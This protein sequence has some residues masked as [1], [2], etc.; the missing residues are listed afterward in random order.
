[1]SSTIT[2]VAKG[3][4][5]VMN[6]LEARKKYSEL[7]ASIEEPT[8]KQQ[9]ERLRQILAEFVKQHLGEDS[10]TLAEPEK[11]MEK[12]VE[13]SLKD[14]ER[15]IN[16][17]HKTFEKQDVKEKFTSKTLE[18]EITE[19]KKEMGKMNELLLKIDNNN[20]SPKHQSAL[21][22]LLD[23]IRYILAHTPDMS[24]TWHQLA[25][26]VSA[27]MVDIVGFFDIAWKGDRHTRDTITKHL[28]DTATLVVKE[29]QSLKLEDPVKAE[30]EK[31]KQ[32][33]DELTN[34][35]S[36]APIPGAAEQRINSQEPTENFVNGPNFYYTA[37]YNSTH[38]T[39]NHTEHAA[40]EDG[41]KK[42]LRLKIENAIETIKGMDAATYERDRAG[43]LAGLE[44]IGIDPAPYKNA[45]KDLTLH[46]LQEKANSLPK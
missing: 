14:L 17:L 22:I 3:S 9:H 29:C 31:L 30:L 36:E 19:I 4:K 40:D 46:M 23:R 5:R 10:E 2:E 20:L 34:P 1:M 37:P 6:A 43:I 8:K 44:G 28:I 16:D 24:W 12:E 33:I 39:E 42:L 18:K 21:N 25:I 32:K 15:L 38:N 45:S 41:E 7:I 27:I 26:T 11:E 13:I 35:K